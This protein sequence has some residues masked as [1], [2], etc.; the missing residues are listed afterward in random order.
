MRLLATYDN[1]SEVTTQPDYVSTQ[2]TG[3][4]LDKKRKPQWTERIPDQTTEMLRLT[5]IKSLKWALKHPKSGLVEGCKGAL[6]IT[7]SSDKKETEWDGD[8]VHAR[9]AG[10]AAVLY[11]VSR[12]GLAHRL[13]EQYMNISKELEVISHEVGKLVRKINGIGK[14]KQTLYRYSTIPR[15]LPL[16]KLR[17]RFPVVWYQDPAFEGSRDDNYQQQLQMDSLTN[18]EPARRPVPVYDLPFLLGKDGVQQLLQDTVFKN[19]HCLI[20]KDVRLNLECQ[21]HLYKLH[22]YLSMSED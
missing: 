14:P 2:L 8:R 15:S 22:G 11:L 20:L 3:H 18:S 4:W 9:S 7:T 17:E 10:P 6:S 5:F 1:I 19:S 12:I 13:C 16:G 21:M